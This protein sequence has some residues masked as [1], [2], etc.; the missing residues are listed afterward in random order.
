M[1]K[2]ILLL[3]LIAH[4]GFAQNKSVP[5]I[6]NNLIKVN[7]LLWDL[8]TLNK[9]PQVEWIN[10]TGTVYS[11]LYKSVD[12]EGK[13]TQVFAYY[14]NPDLISGKMQGKSKFPGVVLIHGGGGQAYKQWVEKWARDGYAA[15]AM[16]LSGKD[17]DGKK[18]AQAGADQGDDNKFQKIQTGNLKDNWTYHAVSS[19]ILA[20]SLLLN[21]PE[22]DAEKTCVT[23]ISWGGFLTCIVASLDNRFKAAVPVYGCG[24]Y[25]ESDVFKE[26]LNKLSQQDKQKWMKYFDPSSYLSFAQPRFLFVNGNKDLFYNVVPYHK[27]YSLINKN[28]R[29]IFIKPDM[30]H[31]HGHGWE[32]NEIHYFFESVVNHGPKLL[33]IT[34]VLNQKSVIKL[35]YQS[36]VMLSM[37]VFY[38]TNDI[39]STNAKREWLTQKAVID[40]DKQTVTIPKPKE[41]FKYAFFYLRD[42]NNISVSSEFIIN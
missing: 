10:K 11:L 29:T 38:Y 25:D 12:Y 9:P 1:K 31:D 32:P 4:T 41:G 13:P 27:T 24:F 16:D 40:P 5:V 2:L 3:L 14:S 19:V 23:G 28:R 42:K 26:P 34:S 39:T 21:L 35:S 30:L 20:H 7:D 15:I 22:V 18:L 37:A 17:G 8:K 33:K 36:P 6:N